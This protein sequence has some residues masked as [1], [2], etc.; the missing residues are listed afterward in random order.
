MYSIVETTDEGDKKEVSVVHSNWV[1]GN[2]VYWP[3]NY[4]QTI[5]KKDSLPDLSW[6]K[7]SCKVLKAEIETLAEARELEK[8]FEFHTNT[9]EENFHKKKKARYEVPNFNAEFDFSKEV[10]NILVLNNEVPPLAALSETP[11]SKTLQTTQLKNAGN[12]TI[13]INY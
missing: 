7:Y 11:I 3:H 5:K 10:S 9:D 1:I 13:M 4:R 2:F 12:K 8:Y 6:A